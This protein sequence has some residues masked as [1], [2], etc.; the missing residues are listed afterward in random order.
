ME[1]FVAEDKSTKATSYH[2]FTNKWGD[3]IMYD[4]NPACIPG[5]LH[6]INEC[7]QRTG[8][9]QL[10]LE[11]RAVPLPNGSLAIDHPDSINFIEKRF[12]NATKYGWDKPCP[13]TRARY[14]EYNV[15]ALSST[16]ARK[17]VTPTNDPIPKELS[18]NYIAAPHKIKEELR[19][20]MCSLAHTFRDKEKAND[21]IAKCGG[22]GFKFLELWRA[23]IAKIKPSG[24][25]L[26]CTLRD[27]FFNRGIVGDL[28]YESLNK[29]FKEFREFESACP[30]QSRKGDA[31]MMT[32]VNSIMISNESTSIA[33]EQL[34]MLSKPPISTY[35]DAIDAARTMLHSTS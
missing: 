26:V 34:L 25:A 20:F 17:T 24:I 1:Q 28:T 3:A 7:I 10:L 27:N 16:P 35:D 31:E 9:Y 33:Y 19:S 22:D 6:D 15:K 5:V 29:Y 11:D 30:P 2:I 23:D 32:H 4:S 13:D 18:K 8:F 14:G 21:L 12:P